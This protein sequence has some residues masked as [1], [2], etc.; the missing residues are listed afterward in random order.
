[1]NSGIGPVDE[2]KKHNVHLVHDLSDVGGHLMDHPM[3]LLRFRTLPGESL[4]FLNEKYN[5]TFYDK[6]KRSRAIAQYLLS[7]SGALTTNIAEAACFFRSDNPK[8]F[9]GLPPLDEDSTSG[10]DAPDLELIV[11]PIA[12]KNHGLEPVT[13]GDLMSIGTIAL[14]P[15]ST[16][17]IT[18]RSNNPFDPPVIDPK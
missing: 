5:N 8:L 14:R 3:P 9:P 13:G 18:L 11:M 7:K 4:N 1:M 15:T 10:P 12:F 16:G 17:R 6:L 2:L